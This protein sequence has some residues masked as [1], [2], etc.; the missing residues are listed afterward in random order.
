MTTLTT[1]IS[2][3][4]IKLLF[5]HFKSVKINDD[6]RR[7]DSIPFKEEV[8]PER[9]QTK[10]EIAYNIIEIISIFE[11]YNSLV[12]DIF[13]TARIR[14]KLTSEITKELS[15]IRHTTDKWKY[16]RNKIGGHVDLGPIN[17]F[18]R[19][20]NYKGV[21]VSNHLEADFKGVLIL[22]MIEGAINSTIEK[23][24]LFP[25]RLVLTKQEDLKKL[26]DKLNSDWWP[27]IALAKSLSMFLY[28]IGKA[29]KM[30]EIRS[31]D[32]GI[33]NF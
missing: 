7:I 32:I 8:S 29:E 22:Q 15:H 14:D 31:E 9:I 12:S 26:V 13:N 33:I 5:L 17:E 2:S 4:Q 24:K 6:I 27:C 21:F 28:S 16:V 23:S 11:N 25:N 3:I 1:E 30:K 19:D 10:G 20:Y 18:C